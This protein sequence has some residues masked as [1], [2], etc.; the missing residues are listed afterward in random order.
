MERKSRTDYTGSNPGQT[1]TGTLIGRIQDP[2]GKAIS[3]AEVELSRADASRSVRVAI[4]DTSGH[5]QWVGLAPGLYSL[6][7]SRTGWQRGRFSN[8]KIERA[9]TLDLY[10]VLQPALPS[11]NN[12]PASADRL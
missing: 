10:I 9:R 3:E 2:Q 7:V 8:L 11:G 6:E 1:Q 5:F 12:Q 4:T